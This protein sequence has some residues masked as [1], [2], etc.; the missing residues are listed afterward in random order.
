[1]EKLIY[2]FL[3]IISLEVSAQNTMMQNTKDALNQDGLKI[4][5]HTSTMLYGFDTR[6]T[7][8]VG[9]YYLDTE[10]SLAT[11]KFY[12]KTISTPK[13][14]VKLDSLTDIQ[15]RVILQ[16]NDMEFN[17][18]D[19]IKVISGTLV[20]GFS[21]QKNNQIAPKN[22]VSTLEF[23]DNYDKVK[24]SFFEVLVDG[25]TKLLEYTKIIT[26]KPDYVE[27]FN[28]GSKDLKI[29]KEKQLFVTNGKEVLRFS[30][31]KKDLL[32]VMADKKPEIEKFMKDNDL[33]VKNRT[34]LLKIFA[35]YNGLSTM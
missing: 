32:E 1:M 28:I 31:N 8:V 6:T 33:T 4:G 20:K 22:Y 23:V 9:S 7:E 2:A 10:W 27:A 29:V 25:K 3:G 5:Q 12:P 24:P 35:Y 19:G 21:L 14:T 17:T 34:D 13:G 16:G 15:I 11:V 30:S 18:P 26:Q